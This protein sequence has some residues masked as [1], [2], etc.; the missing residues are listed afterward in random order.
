MVKFS[1]KN[2]TIILKFFS[3]DNAQSYDDYDEGENKFSKNTENLN[4]KFLVQYFPNLYSTDSDAVTEASTVLPQN[5]TEPVGGSSPKE[6]PISP[7][8]SARV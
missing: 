8:L 7:G 3:Q 6:Q 4:K 5:S 1:P 2:N